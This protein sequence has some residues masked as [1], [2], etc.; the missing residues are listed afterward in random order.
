METS[1]PTGC[2]PLLWIVGLLSGG[3]MFLLF[4]IA[5]LAPLFVEDSP[6]VITDPSVVG[7][8][9]RSL[10]VINTAEVRVLESNPPQ[11]EVIVTGY[12]SDGCQLPTVIE[13]SMTDTRITLQLFRELLPSMACPAVIVDFTEVVRLDGP[14]VPGTT[15][16]LD[17]NG[18]TV[19]FSL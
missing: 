8:P 2:S 9:F 14:F 15:Y 3:V 16:T 6:N 1:Q 11:V 19:A 10:H 12:L 13:Q 7:E 4:G 17:V 18:Q 5:P